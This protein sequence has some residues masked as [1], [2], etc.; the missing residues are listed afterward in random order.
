MRLDVDF[1]NE[2]NPTYT[3]DGELMD[4]LIRKVIVSAN[5]SLDEQT[6]DLIVHDFLTQLEE[7]DLDAYTIR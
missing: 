6:V 3:V 1:T 4:A 5:P 7:G 2:E